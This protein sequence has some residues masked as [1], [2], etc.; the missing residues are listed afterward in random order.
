M[1]FHRFLRRAAAA[2]CLAG[3]AGASFACNPISAVPAVISAPGRYCL[4]QDLSFPSARGI[5]I[6]IQASEVTVDLQGYTLRGPHYGGVA[7]IAESVAVMANNR[8]NITVRDG[9]IV[10][11]GTGV[12]IGGTSTLTAGHLVEK[13]HIDG[14]AAV[15]IGMGAAGSV[16]RDNRITRLNGR[17]Q[18]GVSTKA[19][20]GIYSGHFFWPHMG[21]QIVNNAIVNFNGESSNPSAAIYLERA[22]GTLVEG[23]YIEGGANTWDAPL[24]YGVRMM[25]AADVT[26]MN[27][28]IH[29]VYRGVEYGNQAAGKYSGNVTEAVTVPYTGGTPVGS[30]N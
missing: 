28:R 29:R 27:N 16:V 4:T 11:F 6:D 13:L 5:A 1:P 8:N 30:N 15:G 23:N 7:T 26:V 18:T 22:P 12:S 24:F 3:A 14:N 19:V 25:F 10:G 17:L 2:A 9:R 21:N 20:T